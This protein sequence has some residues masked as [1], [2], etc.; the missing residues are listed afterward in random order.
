MCSCRECDSS[1]VEAILIG[2]H[3]SS[4]PD[5]SFKFGMR[6]VNL[7]VQFTIAGIEDDDPTI[8][9]EKYSDFISQS[10]SVDNMIR[11][12]SICIALLSVV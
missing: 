8:N 5:V 3:H 9:V 4:S 12:F 1:G 10:A 2:H 11:T 7:S 6:L